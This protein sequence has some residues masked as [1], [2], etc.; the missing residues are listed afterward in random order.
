MKIIISLFFLKMSQFSVFLL[1]IYLSNIIFGGGVADLSV[2]VDLS[3]SF[4]VGS[5]K[6]AIE[7][8]KYNINVSAYSKLS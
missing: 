2:A 8:Q 1:I 5:L 7:S 3:T 6:Y 4:G